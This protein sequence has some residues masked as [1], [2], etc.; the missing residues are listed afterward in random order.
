ML[1]K[2]DF[3]AQASC[4][5][6]MFICYNV[7]FPVRAHLIAAKKKKVDF[8]LTSLKARTEHTIPKKGKGKLYTHTY[9]GT[10]VRVQLA[11][12]KPLADQ[13]DGSEI[14]FGG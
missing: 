10:N 7:P 3:I 5:H 1:I 6:F 11:T 13:I 4:L 12:T 8:I 2:N 9:I 14:V